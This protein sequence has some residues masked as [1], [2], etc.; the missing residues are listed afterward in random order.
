MLGPPVITGFRL[1]APSERV[2]SRIIPK[3]IKEGSANVAAGIATVEGVTERV[4]RSFRTCP[5]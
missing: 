4:M 5:R 1:S 2:I 3:E